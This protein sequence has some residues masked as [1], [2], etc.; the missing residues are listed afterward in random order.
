MRGKHKIIPFVLLVFFTINQVLP[1]YL[2]SQPIHK[3]DDTS[4]TDAAKTLFINPLSLL[5]PQTLGLQEEMFISPNY[6]K[7][8]RLIIH[9]KDLHCQY[10]A[11]Q[12]IAQLIKYLAKEYGVNNVLVEGAAG[13]VDTRLFGAFPDKKVLEKVA[14]EFV[15]KGIV[16]GPEYLSMIEFGKIPLELHGLEEPSLYIRNLKAFREVFK[17]SKDTAK[18]IAVADELLE[19]LQNKVYNEELL[20]YVNEARK[21]RDYESEFSEFTS[22]IAGMLE[23][24]GVTIEKWKNVA[25]LVEITR[26]K[27]NIDFD[28]V[29]RQRDDVIQ[30]LT[31]VMIKE[32]VEELVKKSLYFRLKKITGVD[33]FSYLEAVCIRY[34]PEEKVHSYNELFQYFVLVKKQERIRWVTVLK[35]VRKAEG[36]LKELLLKTDDER[37]IDDLSDRFMIIGKLFKLELTRDELIDYRK[38]KGGYDVENVLQQLTMLCKKHAVGNETLLENYDYL[39]GLN[40]VVSYG[41]EFYVTALERDKRMTQEIIDH[42]EKEDITNAIVM[43]G[44]FH[45]QGITEE[46]R[47]KEKSYVVLVPKVDELEDKSTYY[48]LMMD[49]RIGFTEKRTAHLLDVLERK[50]DRAVIESLALASRFSELMTQLTESIRHEDKQKI[51]RQLLAFSHASDETIDEFVRKWLQS[52]GARLSRN[53]VELVLEEVSRQHLNALLSTIRE[54]NNPATRDL[55]FRGIQGTGLKEE[56]ITFIKLLMSALEFYEDELVLINDFPNGD[57][58]GRIE[59]ITPDEFMVNFNR[60]KREVIISRLTA[61]G[62]EELLRGENFHAVHIFKYGVIISYFGESYT[63]VEFDGNKVAGQTYESVKNIIMRKYEPLTVEKRIQKVMT[64]ATKLKVIAE[65]SIAEDSTIVDLVDEL[66]GSY[67]RINEVMNNTVKMLILGHRNYIDIKDDLNDP[68]QFV[69]AVLDAILIGDKE[70]LFRIVYGYGALTEENVPRKKI[71]SLFT[72]GRKELSPFQESI[73]SSI[74]RLVELSR[75]DDCPPLVR[76]SI[77]E[78]IASATKN[79]GFSLVLNPETKK[80]FL[81]ELSPFEKGGM[82]EVFWGYHLDDITVVED[83]KVKKKKQVRLVVGKKTL[84]SAVA[85]RDIFIHLLKDEKKILLDLERK[86]GEVDDDTRRRVIKLVDGFSVFDDE[87]N[88]DEFLLFIEAVDGV[89]LRDIINDSTLLSRLT[90]K[91]KYSI[92][93]FILEGLNFL[94]RDEEGKKIAYRDLKPENIMIPPNFKSAKI[95]DF[96]ISGEDGTSMIAAMGTHSYAPK[97]QVL[98]VDA[99]FRDD[100]F[101][102]ALVVIEIL[103]GKQLAQNLDGIINE[104]S[105][106]SLT[107]ALEKPYERNGKRVRAASKP[108]GR[109]EINHS[110]SLLT[111]RQRELLLSKMGIDRKLAQTLARM[112][113]VRRSDRDLIRVEAFLRRQINGSFWGNIGSWFTNGENGEKLQ[114]E[115]R[116]FSSEKMQQLQDLIGQLSSDRLREIQEQVLQYRNLSSSDEKDIIVTLPSGTD[117][118]IYMTSREQQIKVLEIINKRLLGEFPLRFTK[119]TEKSVLEKSK[120]IEEFLKELHGN[121]TG[122][123]LFIDSIDAAFKSFEKFLERNKDAIPNY[124]DIITMLKGVSIKV[125][126]FEDV[127]DESFVSPYFVHEENSIWY[128]L[129]SDEIFESIKLWGLGYGF[130]G[131]DVDK[132]LKQMYAK[133]LTTMYLD[134]FTEII[135]LTERQEEL[136]PVLSDEKDKILDESI[137]YKDITLRELVTDVQVAR[138]LP[139]EVRDFTEVDLWIPEIVGIRDRE[140]LEKWYFAQKKNKIDPTIERPQWMLENTFRTVYIKLL[141]S[142]LSQMHDLIK[143]PKKLQYDQM[144]KKNH[145]AFTKVP[146]QTDETDEEYQEKVEE[147]L[148]RFFLYKLPKL[149][150]QTTFDADEVQ[151]LISFGFKDKVGFCLPFM[152]YLFSEEE[153]PQKSLLLLK[154]YFSYALINTLFAGTSYAVQQSKNLMQ[155]GIYPLRNAINDF[156]NRINEDVLLLDRLEKGEDSGYGTTGVTQFGIAGVKTKGMT[157][158]ETTFAINDRMSTV[159]SEEIINENTIN[160]GI[161]VIKQGATIA[162]VQDLRDSEE[163]KRS[164]QATRILTNL[165]EIMEQDEVLTKKLL[166]TRL[167]FFLE[168]DMIAFNQQKDIALAY[169]GIAPWQVDGEEVG[170]DTIYLSGNSVEYLLNENV[171][172]LKY[173]LDLEIN[174]KDYRRKKRQELLEQGYSN[175]DIERLKND[176]DP[177]STLTVLTG[178]IMHEKKNKTEVDRLIAEYRDVKEGKKERKGI[179]HNIFIE[180]EEALTQG[181]VQ[182]IFTKLTDTSYKDQLLEAGGLINGLQELIDT[183]SAVQEG[184][185][186]VDLGIIKQYLGIMIERARQQRISDRKQ[187]REQVLLPELDLFFNNMRL[188]LKIEE[189]INSISQDTQ[190]IFF[191]FNLSDMFTLIPFDKDIRTLL[192]DSTHQ[193]LVDSDIAQKFSER[194][195]DYMHVDFGDLSQ[196]EKI[197]I[198]PLI[199]NHLLSADDIDEGILIGTGYVALSVVETELGTLLTVRVMKIAPFT[200]GAITQVID[201]INRKSKDLFSAITHRAIPTITFNIDDFFGAISSETISGVIQQITELQKAGLRFVRFNNW[202]DDDLRNKIVSLELADHDRDRLETLLLGWEQGELSQ[203]T[204]GIQMAG[205]EQVKTDKNMTIFFRKGEKEQLSQLSVA[206]LLAG[207]VGTCEGIDQMEKIDEINDLV[208]RLYK[209]FPQEILEEITGGRLLEEIPLTELLRIALPPIQKD[210]VKEIE[211]Y[212]KALQVLEVMA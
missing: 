193:G 179:S 92:C 178:I 115:F 192:N 188:L 7:D 32:D 186:G 116:E 111:F 194:G 49:E 15:K 171:P 142:V 65:D 103:T 52:L 110:F 140:R 97:E 133:L 108:R 80:A 123:P 90:L 141:F 34:L 39:Q 122:F 204:V 163:A 173:M 143:D 126:R 12:N 44:G 61:S 91:Q 21:M 139:N 183:V 25:L 114:I 107:E 184:A 83:G 60:S 76:S 27:K 75:L 45:S 93:Y 26:E 85:Q 146:I 190:E 38:R 74:L 152:E 10:D 157:R 14:K 124:E 95:I 4:Q 98:N 19:K 78:F 109:L 11:Q 189:I 30:F 119:S 86:R 6:N 96:G 201:A 28:L 164:P 211:H 196:D 153:N 70:Q 138:M 161:I 99:D 134:I 112:I 8:P 64:R 13:M 106:K 17:K 121:E 73:A 72:I 158:L 209:E 71:E 100:Y 22:F 82:G 132:F 68:E 208:K 202:T 46:L 150:G 162:E 57:E 205:G 125:F 79:S 149:A 5:I 18:F 48:Q 41:E 145:L 56:M 147:F 63:G 210:F 1:V 180:F 156:A 175:E 104:I 200:S 199:I 195:I 53:D 117:V 42:M 191:D 120:N 87:T 31:E 159:F 3:S 55:F 166:E 203:K 81:R 50:G 174:R 130:E 198:F 43:A 167:I 9:I 154:N 101:S 144:R 69:K 62:V 35:E 212:Y 187:L 84:S 40:E 131:E 105:I 37:E 58:V 29:E 59:E 88:A 160:N 185:D 127:L 47:R 155:R 151:R 207:L 177:R 113:S 66:E 129:I 128:V 23:R 137:I 51:I 197:T 135:K 136:L 16:T 24:K 20:L 89:T 181:I 148:N 2:Y 206:L 102:Y 77:N 67:K 172:V 33:Y 169:T 54:L 36:A 170:L 168:S 94:H 182:S 165:M 176:V 118:V